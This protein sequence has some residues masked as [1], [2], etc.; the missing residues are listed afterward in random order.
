MANKLSKVCASWGRL[1]IHNHNAY[2][3]K[4]TH[5][6]TESSTDHILEV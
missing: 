1:G 5:R 4:Y 3:H 6:N 2:M